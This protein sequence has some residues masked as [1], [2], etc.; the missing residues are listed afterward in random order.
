MTVFIPA[1]ESLGKPTR[2]RTSIEPGGIRAGAVRHVLGLVARDDIP[3]VAGAEA[4]LTSSMRYGPTCGDRRHWPD[5]VRAAPAPAGAALE[6]LERSIERGATLVS[7]GPY[8]NLALLEI[9]R[10]GSLSRANVVVMGGWVHAPADGLPPWGP[11]MDWNVQCDTRAAQIVAGAAASLTLAT[12]PAT[13]RAPLRAAHLPRLR[14]AGALGALLARQSEAHAEDMGMPALGRAHAALP[15]DL[16]NFLYD[17]VA[18]ALAVGWSAAVVEEMRLE[19]AV[20]TGV[21]RFRPSAEGRAMRVL[22]D[23]DP[24]A[25]R[26]AWLASVERAGCGR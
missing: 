6:L 1:P 12:L 22:I 18:C 19:P 10:R 16:L 8:T 25:F 14:A 13:L 2:G 21:L 24:D 4:T 5:P 9:A 3:V 26:E 17:P 23:L 7:I 11:E 15:D 20:E